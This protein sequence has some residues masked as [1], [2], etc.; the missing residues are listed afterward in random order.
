MKK[1]DSKGRFVRQFPIELR[2]CLVCKNP[3]IVPS[4]NPKK[5]CSRSCRNKS[6][7]GFESPYW[8]GGKAYRQKDGYTRVYVSK[9]K[10]MQE[11]RAV[12]EKHLGRKLLPKEG[13]HHRNGIKND[14]RLE[15]LELVGR[16]HHYGKI[17]CPHCQ[18]EFLIR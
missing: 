4:Y 6:K 14:N 10:Y 7:S 17:V 2:Q 3:F 5:F 13:V 18:K 8:K 1:T 12:M 15:N 16:P 9:G 11:H